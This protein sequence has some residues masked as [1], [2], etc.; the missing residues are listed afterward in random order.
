M[1]VPAAALGPP[2]A[3]A[4]VARRASG[5]PGAEGDRMNRISIPTAITLALASLTV[6]AVAEIAG[7]EDLHPMLSNAR[8]AEE[9]RTRASRAGTSTFPGKMGDT[10]WVGYNPAYAGSNYWSI[11]VGNRRPRGTTGPDPA[12]ILPVPAEDTGYWDWDH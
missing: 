12:D 9:S 6:P 11:G 10:T 1:G 3:A 4:G 8:I 2:D 7:T 5:V